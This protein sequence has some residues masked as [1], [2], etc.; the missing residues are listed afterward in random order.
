VPHEF[1]IDSRQQR[2][3]TLPGT[4]FETVTFPIR[5]PQR[6]ADTE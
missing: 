3:R 5:Y 4:F 6:G 2:Q 1:R